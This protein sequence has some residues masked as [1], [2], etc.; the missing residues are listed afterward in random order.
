MLEAFPAPWNWRH[1]YKEGSNQHLAL[2][3]ETTALNP[4]HDDPMILA[5]RDDT[6]RGFD[7]MNAHLIGT[8]P[9]LFRECVE[10][11]NRLEKIGTKADQ[12]QIQKATAVILKAQG[13]A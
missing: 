11:R 10:L 3:L 12:A 9:E 4:P 6:I 5:V 1:V 13:K 2:I 7:P 8:A